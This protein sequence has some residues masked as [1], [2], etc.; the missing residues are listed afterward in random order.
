MWTEKFQIQK[1]DFKK[2]KEPEVKLPTSV[3][4][5]KKQENSRNT[6]ASSLITLKPLTVWIT[7]NCGK[8]L[9]RW[10]Y[11][12]TLP[13]SWEP[14]MQEALLKSSNIANLPLSCLAVCLAYLWCYII[15][16]SCLYS[17]D[18]WIHPPLSLTLLN[19]QVKDF[20]IRFCLSLQLSNFLGTQ[21]LLRPY[22][23]EGSQHCRRQ[24]KW[25]LSSSNRGGKRE[26][27]DCEFGVLFL[28][29]NII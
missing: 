2:V 24:W 3:G 8:F 6:S 20:D 28:H 19:F 4:S 17:P 29:W 14:C 23:K 9:K 25:N 22:L 11:Q 7:T 26:G 1:L 5:Q 18:F 27:G 21:K 12:T 15:P 10:E 16:Y 13:A